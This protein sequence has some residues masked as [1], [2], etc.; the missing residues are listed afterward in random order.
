MPERPT[1]HRGR[2]TRARP[3]S[4]RPTATL[5][6]Y[7]WQWQ[8][9][10]TWFLAQYPLCALCHAIGRV[11]EATVVD[12]KIPHRGDQTLFWDETNWQSLCQHCHNHKTATTDRKTR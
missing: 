11:R 2:P 10:R 4:P 6:G 1:T 3:V 9:A 5:R 7:G 12:H 8:Q